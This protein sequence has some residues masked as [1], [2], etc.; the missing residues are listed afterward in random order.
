MYVRHLL[1]TSETAGVNEKWSVHGFSTRGKS[2]IQNIFI[3]TKG[4][5]LVY[6]EVFS[7]FVLSIGKCLSSFFFQ[8][9]ERGH[10]CFVCA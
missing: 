3:V 2:C 8:A 6:F 10:R 5:S 9:V 7:G 4:C 1:F